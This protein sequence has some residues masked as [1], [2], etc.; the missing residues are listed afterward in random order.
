MITAHHL[1][2][3]RKYAGVASIPF[4]N[5]TAITQF[6]F[7]TRTGNCIINWGDGNNSNFIPSK[8][9]DIIN[10]SATSADHNYSSAYTGNVNIAFNNGL[11]DV[12]SLFL[13]IPQSFNTQVNTFNIQNFNEFINQFSNLYSLKISSYSVFSSVQ[14]GNIKGNIADVPSSVER[15]ELGHMGALINPNELYLDVTNFKV[16]SNLKWLNRNMTSAGGGLVTTWQTYG[17][18]AKLPSQLYYFKLDGNV[19]TFTYSGIKVWA[20]SFDTLDIGNASLSNSDTDN[21][22]IDMAN[23]I[24]TAIG[25]KI[26]RLANCYRTSASDT[27]VSYLQSLGFTITVNFGAKVLDLPLQNNFIDTTGIN[28]MIAGGTSNLPTFTIDSGEY[29]AT[30]NGTQSIKTNANLPLSTDKVSISF[31]MK[32]SQTATAV[33]TELGTNTTSNNSFICSTNDTLANRISITDHNSSGFNIGNSAININ[34]NSWH[35]VVLI[36][37]RNLGINQNKIYIDGVLSYTQNSAYQTDL[38]GNWTSF[39]L[40]I[41]QR[42]GSL[43][44]FNGKLKFLKIFNFPLSTTEI[45]NLYNKTM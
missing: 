24:T 11:A 21:L 14:K 38:S 13:F 10:T 43:Y 3:G 4:N 7:S 23:F 6:Q 41:G 29:A 40:Y 12:Y 31:W 20:S 18:L 27:S 16:G 45:T 17:N 36:I 8:N 28:T 15:I 9:I 25:S 34:D 35:H 44:G 42:G 26:I 5:I 33:I 2:F 30:F 37:D 19:G 39:P 1:V 22:F 32:T